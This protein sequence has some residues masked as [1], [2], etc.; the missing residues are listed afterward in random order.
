M[1]LYLQIFRSGL[2]LHGILNR[3][4]R[5]SII[6][7]LLTVLCFFPNQFLQAQCDTVR[8][9]FNEDIADFWMVSDINQSCNTIFCYL[10][11]FGE[12]NREV[13]KFSINLNFIPGTAPDPSK[14]N[15]TTGPWN[16]DELG[17]VSL[18][19]ETKDHI[20]ITIA[21]PCGNPIPRGSQVFKI[22]TLDGK[23]PSADLL[24]AGGIV[25][26]EITVGFILPLNDEIEAPI[27]V[28]AI[29]ISD[30]L[31]IHYQAES[32]AQAYLPLKVH[33]GL[34]GL[35]IHENNGTIT[36]KK[37]SIR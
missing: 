30:G 21:R 10:K 12:I 2:P 6:A 15:L 11:D 4:E 31:T 13:L 37:V 22:E 23:F 24:E 26:Q 34:W 32:D 25:I 20:K 14:W 1:N 17:S 27:E 7:T 16:A 36:Y 29:R 5:S 3:H 35:R 28:T 8:C 9:E 18:V 33:R 19:S